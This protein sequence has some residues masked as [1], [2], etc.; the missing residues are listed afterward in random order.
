MVN[1]NYYIRGKFV[2]YFCTKPKTNFR[3]SDFKCFARN[4]SNT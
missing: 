2:S 3:E 1:K 4:C